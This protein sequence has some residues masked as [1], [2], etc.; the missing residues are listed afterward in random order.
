[1]SRGPVSRLR[2]WFRSYVKSCRRGREKFGVWWLV[3]TV[4][5]LLVSVSF[6]VYAVAVYIIFNA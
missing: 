3:F 4:G 6:F 1:M 5:M 2:D